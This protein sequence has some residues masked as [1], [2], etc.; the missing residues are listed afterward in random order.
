MDLQTETIY[1]AW[2]HSIQDEDKSEERF[3]ELF[4]GS[5]YS[6]EGLA[7]SVLEGTGD[8]EEFWQNRSDH[9]LAYYFKFD[10]EN[11]GRDLSLNDDVW[12]ID[13]DG[14]YHYFWNNR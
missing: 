10:Y 2:K 14:M 8:V 3:E 4:I 6:Y 11:F 9:Y 13:H 5:F 12:S 7:E 1:K